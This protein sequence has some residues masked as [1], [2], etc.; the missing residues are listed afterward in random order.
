MIARLCHAAPSS[1]RRPEQ[2]RLPALAANAAER[3]ALELDAVLGARA[4]PP[5]VL[6]AEPE[7]A[8]AAR[9]ELRRD[10][11]PGNTWPPVPPAVIITVPGHRCPLHRR[12]ARQRALR[13]LA[14]AVRHT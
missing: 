14:D 9:D 4:S 11:E 2:Q 1:A 10:G 3:H 13:S 6:R 7:H 8:P 12:A 5:S